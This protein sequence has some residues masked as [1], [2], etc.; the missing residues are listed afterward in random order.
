[1][2]EIDPL[3]QPLPEFQTIDLHCLLQITF[4]RVSF[5]SCV[6]PRPKKLELSG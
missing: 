4:T 3:Y 5:F 6:L 2:G 1:M